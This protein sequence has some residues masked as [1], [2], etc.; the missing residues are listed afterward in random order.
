MKEGHLY[1]A[2]REQGDLFQVN[3][4]RCWAVVTNSVSSGGW[5]VDNTAP[6]AKHH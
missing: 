2:I 4:K 3:S 6:K 5:L 1:A